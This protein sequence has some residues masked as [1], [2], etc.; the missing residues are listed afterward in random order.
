MRTLYFD[1][2]KQVISKDPQCDYSNLV[3]GSEGYLELSFRFSKEW[4]GFVKVAAFYSPLGREYPPRNLAD[5][6]SCVIPFEALEKRSFKVQVIGKK[7]DSRLKTNK[8]V[9]HQNGGIL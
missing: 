2:D 1:V 7:N 8:L 3:V 9:V 5:G 6:K 4:D